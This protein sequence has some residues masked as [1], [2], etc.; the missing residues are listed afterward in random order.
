M[1]EESKS[2]SYDRTPPPA[3][4]RWQFGLLFAFVLLNLGG[5]RGTVRGRLL[6]DGTVELVPTTDKTIGGRWFPDGVV[7]GEQAL[8]GAGLPATAPAA[9]QEVFERMQQRREQ[10]R[11]NSG[12]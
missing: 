9:A 3:I 12:K 11:V 8:G 6:G 7:P 4:P 5:Q 2:L 1:A 10:D